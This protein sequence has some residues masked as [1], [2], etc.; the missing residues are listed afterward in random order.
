MSPAERNAEL[1]NT[2]LFG[3]VT[4]DP[5]FPSEQEWREANRLVPDATLAHN[6]A[7]SPFLVTLPPTEQV[8]TQIAGLGQSLPAVYD[9]RTRAE[10]L[11]VGIRSLE[12]TP[13]IATSEVLD[14]SPTTL[15]QH[16][17]R[18]G[19]YLL[20]FAVD[21]GF[22]V[23]YSK[24]SKTE[25]HDED[26]Q[27]VPGGRYDSAIIIA[28]SQYQRYRGAIVGSLPHVFVDSR[29]ELTF[30]EREWFERTAQLFGAYEEQLWRL[31]EHAGESRTKLLTV[32][33]TDNPRYL[34]ELQV[35]SSSIIFKDNIPR[36]I[37][38]ALQSTA[39]LIVGHLHPA[40]AD[41]I[42]LPTGR[43]MNASHVVYRTR[44]YFDAVHK[45]GELFGYE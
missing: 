3:E 22:S 30:L 41:S 11:A 42:N 26:F 9:A 2:L 20:K 13:V 19:N 39:Q 31:V 7:R 36:E 28:P 37:E 33:E 6:L 8:F 21:Q 34:T 40:K 44:T 25:L 17:M 43:V 5:A 24:R 35:V 29:H 18:V 27:P 32:L 45:S 15:I 16:G 10:R 12:Q 1:A 4:I 14:H 38:E 23:Q